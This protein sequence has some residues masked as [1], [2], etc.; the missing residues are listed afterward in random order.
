MYRN[1]VYDNRRKSIR[2]WTWDDDGERVER[3]IP[4]KPH[5]YFEHKNGKDG[6]SIFK[7]PLQKREF[8][9]GFDRRKWVD[10]AGID[11]IFDNL[12]PEQQFLIDTYGDSK[13]QS[14][15]VENPL[16]I[17]YL[18]IEVYSPDEF[19]KADEAKHPVNLITLFDS[20]DGKYHTWGTDA[21]K[22]TESNVIYTEC[23]SESAL[24]RAFMNYWTTNYPD[25]VT[26]WNGD[27]FD[28]PYIVNRTERLFGADYPKRLSPTGRIWSTEK[29]DRFKNPITEWNIQGV[30]CIDYLKAYKKFSR[31]ERESY[32]LGYIGELEV[33]EGKI[34]HEGSLAELADKDWDTFV[35]YN[36]RDCKILVKMEH[37][38]HFLELCRMIAYKG[39]TKFEKALATNNVVAGAFALQARKVNLIIPTFNYEKGGKPP[40]GLVRYPENGFNDD[41]TSFDAKSLYPNTIISMNLSPE[42]KLGQ[43]YTD[44]NFTF[45]TTVRGKEFKLRNDEFKAWMVKNNVCKSVHGTLFT[46]NV[47]G[48]IPSIIEDIYSDR[49]VSQKKKD[50]YS[51]KLAKLKPD[52]VEYLNINKR[53]QEED[54]MQYTLKILM[55]S[56]YGTFGNHHSCLYDLDCAGSITLTGQETNAQAVLAVRNYIRDVHKCDVPFLIYGDTDSIYITLRPLFDH[57]GI[58]LLK[59]EERIV[60]KAMEITPE[61]MQ[62]IKDLGGEGNPMD[63]AITKHLSKWA[64]D[65]MNS[66]DPRFVFAR[67]KICKRGI[68]MNAKKRYAIQVV[69][70]DGIPVPVGGKKEFSYTGID[71]IVT[72]THAKEVQNM[73]KVVVEE[74]LKNKDMESANIAVRKLYDEFCALPPETLA[75]RKSMKDL[76]KYEKNADGFLIGKGTPQNSKA[77]LIYNNLI[78]HLTL[79]NVYEK[80]KSGDKIKIL[81]VA[82]NRFGIDYVGFKDVFPPEFDMAPNFSLLYKKQAHPVMDRIFT[83]VSWD[84]IDPTKSY[85]CDVVSEF[86]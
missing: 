23:T 46:Q 51:R 60:G 73:L 67:E 13:D 21:Y 68:F 83:A 80:I 54:T 82:K 79:G 70:S 28:I 11:R 86:S 55:N 47:K 43:T 1:I 34:D 48:I 77:S 56:I 59:S 66:T 85:V 57:L 8:E 42:T 19:P 18:D 40:G 63:G 33:D 6:L 4:F 69:D 17:F 72:A 64:L 22:G 78:D 62:I 32:T 14:A 58:K 39:L 9:N 74:M 24:F 29:L 16:R 15:F 31:N 38:L 25:V 30:S 50:K 44:D 36:I 41:I 12:P 61:A 53:V 45:V 65:E 20:L 2:L 5:I 7:T 10:S 26:N 76:K 49:I 84:I 37:K 35:K 81:Y 3:L 27:G 71:G 52:D 75:N